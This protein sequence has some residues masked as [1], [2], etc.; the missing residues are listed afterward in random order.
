MAQSTTPTAERV[1]VET[2]AGRFVFK[3]RP[4]GS[5]VVKCKG[6]ERIRIRPAKNPASK[7]VQWEADGKEFN[8]V[9]AETII[10]GKNP[11]Q[12][13]KRAVAHFWLS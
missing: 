11:Q 12:A 8:R 13:Y 9:G 2:K 4:N 1:V 10:T 5:F 6:F 3:S 7:D